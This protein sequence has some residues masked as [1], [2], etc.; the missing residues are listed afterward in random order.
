[1]RVLAIDDGGIRGIYACHVLNKI[2]SRENSNNDI[3][4]LSKLPHGE[5]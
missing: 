5:Y 4:S 2:E 3:E 1:M